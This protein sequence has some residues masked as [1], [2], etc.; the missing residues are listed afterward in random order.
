[1]SSCNSKIEIFLQFVPFF[2][3]LTRYFKTE[4][5]TH[6]HVSGSGS[7]SARVGAMLTPYIAQVLLRQSVY[8]AVAVYALLG[9]EPSCCCTRGRVLTLS[10]SAGF[11]AGVVSLLLSVE[12]SGQELDKGDQ[13]LSDNETPRKHER[14]ILEEPKQETQ[15]RF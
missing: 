7:A 2:F 14:L 9:K 5:V 8:W 12:T 3:L 6:A 4:G 10:F 11:I 1:M 13:S 15:Q